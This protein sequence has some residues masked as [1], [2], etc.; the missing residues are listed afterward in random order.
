M[1]SHGGCEHKRTQEYHPST[2]LGANAPPNYPTPQNTQ[3]LCPEISPASCTFV[4]SESELDPVS[5]DYK[6]DWHRF[7][8]FRA[9]FGLSWPILASEARVGATLSSNVAIHPSLR[10]VLGPNFV[11][12]AVLCRGTYRTSLGPIQTLVLEALNIGL[13][14][15]QLVVP[16][17]VLLVVACWVIH[18]ATAVR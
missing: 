4:V 8:S 7:W 11:G 9:V 5:M 12:L 13:S 15:C 6:P 2:T 1:F 10:R 3:V 16:R 14:A 18:S 17:Y